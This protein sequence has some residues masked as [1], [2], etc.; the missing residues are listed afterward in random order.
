MIATRF[1]Y[2]ILQT[3][4]FS[5]SRMLQAV[6]L[7]R[8]STTSSVNVNIAEARSLRMILSDMVS[9]AAGAPLMIALTFAFPANVAACQAFTSNERWMAW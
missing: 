1:I 7:N 2:V 4:G 9:R 6:L 3:V 5:Y 8:T